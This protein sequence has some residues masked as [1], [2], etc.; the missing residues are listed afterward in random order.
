MGQVGNPSSSKR[1]GETVWRRVKRGVGQVTTLMSTACVDSETS[2]YLFPLLRS[3]VPE[4]GGLGLLLLKLLLFPLYFFQL[5]KCQILEPFLRKPFGILTF[6]LW[7]W[8]H[9]WTILTLSPVSLARCSRT[10]E[11][12]S[13]C[14][15]QREK[16]TNGVLVLQN[17]IQLRK[18]WE[19]CYHFLFLALSSI[20]NSL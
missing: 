20:E 15:N 18:D 10:W 16:S 2:V 13:F 3:W 12:E 8:N 1:R 5:S 11:R 14:G 9:T 7:F 6:A 4:R 19:S 17:L